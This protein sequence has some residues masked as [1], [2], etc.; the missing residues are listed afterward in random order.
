MNGSGRQREGATD[1]LGTKWLALYTYAY[2]PLCMFLTRAADGV[3]KQKGAEAIYA[4]TD[5]DAMTSRSQLLILA[6]SLILFVTFGVIIGL[7]YRKYWAWQCN[8]LLLLITALLLLPQLDAA[9]FVT[10]MKVLFITPNI[11]YF[12]KRKRLFT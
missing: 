7:H 12:Y 5:M 1:T 11:V 4:L 10:S 3:R 8:W 9:V 2:L 6:D